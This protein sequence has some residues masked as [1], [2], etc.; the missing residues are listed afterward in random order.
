[1][2]G[3]QCTGSAYNNAGHF[4]DSIAYCEGIAYR[5]S[6][7]ALSKPITANP[8]VFGIWLCRFYFMG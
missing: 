2:P 1:M 3:K 7:T 4:R 5:A 6:G 8:H